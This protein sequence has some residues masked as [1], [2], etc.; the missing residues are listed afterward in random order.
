MHV[1]YEDDYFALIDKPPGIPVHSH[2]KHNIFNIAA[3]QLKRCDLPDALPHPQPAH[4]LDSLTAGLLIISKNRYFQVEIG[5][6]FEN[7]QISKR[8]TAIVLGQPLSPGII[9]LPVDEKE[10]YTTYEVLKQLQVQSWGWLSLIHLFPKTGRTHQLRIHCARSG[11][12]VFGERKYGQSIKNIRGKGLFLFADKIT[13]EHPVTKEV[14]DF[15][16][17]LPK[18]FKKY[19][20]LL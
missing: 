13:F 18:K 10:A 9:E 16:L 3:T 19:F 17:P 12:P 15:E 8:Y 6:Q 2:G 1:I 14:M 11:F 5:K 4:R 7:K 20:P